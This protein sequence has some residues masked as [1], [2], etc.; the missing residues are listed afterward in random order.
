LNDWEEKVF[1]GRV[2]YRIESEDSIA[3]VDA[4][5]R[6]AA[7]ALYHKVD[8]DPKKFPI[9]SWKWRVSKFPKKTKAE[10]LESLEEHDFAARVYVI[11]PT[12]FIMNSNVLEYLWAEELPVGTVGTSPYSKNIRLMVLENGPAKDGEWRTEERDIIADYV[13]AFGEAPKRDIGAISFMTNAEHTGS[14]AEAMYD[15]IKLGYKESGK[16]DGRL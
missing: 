3:Y 12:F 1:K 8:L 10:N 6:A 4:N 7:S 5:S 16:G 13:K 15:D 11:F 2:E 14:S 9:I